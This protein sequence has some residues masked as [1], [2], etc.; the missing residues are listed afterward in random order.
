MT[1]LNWWHGIE[2]PVRCWW[3]ALVMSAYNLGEEKVLGIN[4]LKHRQEPYLA[5]Q[6]RTIGVM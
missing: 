3:L 1:K 4:N 6:N 5:P 2:D